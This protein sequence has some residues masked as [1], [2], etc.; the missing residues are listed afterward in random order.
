M[1]SSAGEQVLMPLNWVQCYSEPLAPQLSHA[2]VHY[3]KNPYSLLQCC[4]LCKMFLKMGRIT[5]F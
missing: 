4:L 5:R 1:P 2:V 3:T